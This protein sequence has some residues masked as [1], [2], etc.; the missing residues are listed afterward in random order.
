[1]GVVVIANPLRARPASP[2]V[3]DVLVHWLLCRRAQTKAPRVGS[4]A[5]FARSSLPKELAAYR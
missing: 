1:M 5:K 2:P 4:G 3:N